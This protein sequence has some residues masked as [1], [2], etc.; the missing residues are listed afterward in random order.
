MSVI[1]A[2]CATMPESSR[3]VTQSQLADGNGRIYLL[4]PTR[5]SIGGGPVCLIDGEE[6]GRLTPGRVIVADIKAGEHTVSFRGLTL[7]D[8]PDQDKKITVESGQHKYIRYQVQSRAVG[9][10]LVAGRQQ[11]A[12]IDELPEAVGRA[13]VKRMTD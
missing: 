9:G 10:I 2:G 1:L 6:K 5:L 12:V 4:H 11:F 13:D 7:F 3:A 8:F